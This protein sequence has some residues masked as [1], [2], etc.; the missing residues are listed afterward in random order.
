MSRLP[1]SI[2]TEA[3]PRPGDRIDAALY[4]GATIAAVAA[5]LA[6][7]SAVGYLIGLWLFN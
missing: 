3:P 7:G 2:A 1:F 5:L 6:G 4:W